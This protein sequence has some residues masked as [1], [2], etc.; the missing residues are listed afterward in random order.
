MAVP[1]LRNHS[2]GI[3]GDPLPPMKTPFAAFR[4]FRFFRLAGI[5]GNDSTIRAR[6]SPFSEGDAR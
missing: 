3:D 5:S 2:P 4:F 1:P 6:R